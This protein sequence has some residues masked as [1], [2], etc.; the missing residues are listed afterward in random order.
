MTVFAL[1][2]NGVAVDCVLADSPDLLMDDPR[3]EIPG[4]RWIET[5]GFGGIGYVYDDDRQ[6]FMP[7]KPFAS[8]EWD[9]DFQTWAP[10]HA[11]PTNEEMRWRWD[12]D[13][14]SW[15]EASAN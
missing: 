12:E 5:N 11:P 6:M 3:L 4:S 15:V 8:W 7:P 2:V 1:T 10:P 14:L 13:T 9:A